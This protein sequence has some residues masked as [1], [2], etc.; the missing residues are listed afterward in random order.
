MPVLGNPRN[1]KVRIAIVLTIAIV[2]AFISWRTST[3]KGCEEDRKEIRDDAGK[4]TKIERTYC[5]KG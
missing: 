3:P 2:A 1:R 4:I 5:A